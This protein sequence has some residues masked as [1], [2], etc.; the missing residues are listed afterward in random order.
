MLDGIIRMSADAG[1]KQFSILD[2][3]SQNVSNMNTPGYKAKE[4]QQ[5]LMVDGTIGG[6]ERVDTSQGQ[7]VD[8]GRELDIA[9]KGKGYFPL[10]QPD[11][12]IA[13]TR[14]ASFIRNKDGFITSMRGDILGEGIRVPAEANKIV[15]NKTGDVTALLP[16]GK[17]VEVGKI[18]LVMFRNP[19][20]LQS[21]GYNK[22]VPTS[23][24]GAAEVDTTGSTLLQGRIEQANVNMYLQIDQILRLNAGLISNLR[25]V[26]Y[27]DDVYKQAANLRQ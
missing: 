26:K 15:V 13:Y 24:S 2:R 27:I 4:F 20:G 22:L 3:V 12:S 7:M 11:G 17:E 10:T 19:E 21:I 6:V 9:I 18:G 25:V 8:T 1:I 16:E 14:D 5:Y 23:M